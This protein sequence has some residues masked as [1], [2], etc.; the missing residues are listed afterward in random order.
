MSAGKPDEALSR[1]QRLCLL[2]APDAVK[3]PAEGGSASWWTL[4]EWAQS[5]VG[6]EDLFQLYAQMMNALPHAAGEDREELF[7]ASEVVLLALDDEM[8]NRL[9]QIS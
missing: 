1:Y 3:G 6:Q 2:P 8:V 7:R 9:E 5:H 4:G